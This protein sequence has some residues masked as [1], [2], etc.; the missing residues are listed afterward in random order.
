MQ[1]KALVLMLTILS[2]IL[3]AKSLVLP[4]F[5]QVS[6]EAQF[7]GQTLVKLASIIFYRSH[8]TEAE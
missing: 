7:F 6:S 5:T 4:G 1:E 2:T 3:F 8:K